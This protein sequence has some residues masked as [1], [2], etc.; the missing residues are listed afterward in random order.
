MDT[1]AAGYSQH[2]P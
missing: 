2:N 1:L